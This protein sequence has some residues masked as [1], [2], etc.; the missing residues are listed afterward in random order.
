MQLVEKDAL[1]QDFQTT[2]LVTLNNRIQEL[3]VRNAQLQE[4]VGR[5]KR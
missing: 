5:S 1:L 2:D 3:S 4:Q